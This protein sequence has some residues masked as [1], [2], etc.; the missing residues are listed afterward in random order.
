MHLET[1]KNINKTVEP[2]LP[3]PPPHLRLHQLTEGKI[4]K[5]VNN[6]VL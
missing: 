3:P 1:G 6:G 2:P 4:K 5:E